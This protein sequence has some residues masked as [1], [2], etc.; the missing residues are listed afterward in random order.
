VR[1]RNLR[2]AGSFGR[3]TVKIKTADPA[4]FDRRTMMRATQQL[5]DELETLP[6]DEQE[7]RAASYLDD[8][9][10][11]K[12]AE[13]EETDEDPYSALKILRDAKLVGPEDAS[14]TYEEKLYGL[15]TKND[16]A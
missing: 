11:S 15:N 6:D 13:E 9:Y 7:A 10:R 12:E 8:L 4:P 2:R 1:G 16:D 5:F 3:K 14:V